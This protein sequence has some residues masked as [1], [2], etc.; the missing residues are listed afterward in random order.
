MTDAEI[1]A[2]AEAIADTFIESCVEGDVSA[3]SKA[4]LLNQLAPM[5]KEGLG[6][7]GK[8]ILPALALLV[9][10]RLLEPMILRIIGGN[11]GMGCSM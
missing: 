5:L 7:L 1:E 9:G 8:M 2:R 10:W 11:Y 3:D 4:Q 6:G